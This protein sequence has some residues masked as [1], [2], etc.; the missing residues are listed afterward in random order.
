MHAPTYPPETRGK[1]SMLSY[2]SG[3]NFV[4]SQQ[5]EGLINTQDSSRLAKII[6]N[7]QKEKPEPVIA[8]IG[9]GLQIRDPVYIDI[10]HSVDIGL[11]VSAVLAILGNPNKEHCASQ[12]QENSHYFLN[13]LEFGF[14]LGF[15]AGDHILRK[16]ILRTNHLADPYF[17]FHDRCNFVIQVTDDQQITPLTRFSEIQPALEAQGMMSSSQSQRQ[18]VTN[19]ILEKHFLTK[20]TL[21]Y[22]Y[23][24]L[25]VEVLQNTD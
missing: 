25:L 23:K 15:S 20:K 17:G 7:S 11:S 1:L 22:G 19:P 10:V 14:D 4:F 18:V 16:I 8:T 9:K 13:Y 3:I 21:T 24:G 6:I 2:Q 12:Q 5:E